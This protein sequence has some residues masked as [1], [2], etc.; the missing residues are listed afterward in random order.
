MRADTPQARP[1]L[2]AMEALLAAPKSLTVWT[3]MIEKMRAA[4]TSMVW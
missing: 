1:T 4:M 2:L 3:T